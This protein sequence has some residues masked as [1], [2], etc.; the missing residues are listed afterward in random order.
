MYNFRTFRY[1]KSKNKNKIKKKQIAKHNMVRTYVLSVQYRKKNAN[2]FFFY[3]LQ[4]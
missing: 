3:D 1:V 2:I 4:M